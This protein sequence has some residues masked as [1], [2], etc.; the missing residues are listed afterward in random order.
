LILA[1]LAFILLAVGYLYK[2]KALC[3]NH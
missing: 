1:L 2:L 3:E